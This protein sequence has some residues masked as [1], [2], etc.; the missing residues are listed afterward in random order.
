MPD[1]PIVEGQAEAAPDATGQAPAEAPETFEVAGQQMTLDSLKQSYEN[2]RSKDTQTSQRNSDLEAQLKSLEWAG[3][4]QDW[5]NANPDNSRK[6]DELYNGQ[7]N[8]GIPSQ[9]AQR[10]DALETKL[11]RGEMEGE[12]NALKEQGL[13][14][15]QGMKEKMWH[16]IA[17]SG[18]RDVKMVYGKLFMMEN[19]QKAGAQA[20]TET[21]SQIAEGHAASAQDTSTKSATPASSGYDAAKAYREDPAQHAANVQADIAKRFGHLFG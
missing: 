6:L 10:I 11:L 4:L 7:A 18:V 15:D 20:V 9:E 16:E 21:A 12:M 1:E 13:P 17:T 19:I 3:P 14:L 2:M 8:E 5:Y